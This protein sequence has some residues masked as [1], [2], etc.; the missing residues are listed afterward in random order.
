MDTEASQHGAELF[1]Y[2]ILDAEAKK[3]SGLIL[4]VNQKCAGAQ[5]DHQVAGDLFEWAEQM[6]K[7]GRL[8]EAEF[9]YL[10]AINIWERHIV[11]AYPINFV[12]LRGYAL[13]LLHASDVNSA[14]EAP[15][16]VSS[17]TENVPLI[18][19]NAA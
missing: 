15:S 2:D 16:N 9:L 12:S 5:V 11:L 18:E 7:A 8:P 3:I 13:M 14:K 19:S 1:S 4:A 6:S 17:I 10:H